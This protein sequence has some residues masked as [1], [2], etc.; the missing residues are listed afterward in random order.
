MRTRKCFSEKTFHSFIFIV[1]CFY[2]T[3]IPPPLHSPK[4][5][6]L[7]R[8]QITVL[9]A[10]SVCVGAKGMNENLPHTRSTGCQP[11]ARPLASLNEHSIARKLLWNFLLSTKRL[12]VHIVNFTTS[13]TMM[14]MMTMMSWMRFNEKSLHSKLNLDLAPLGFCCRRSPTCLLFLLTKN[15]RSD[16][17][18]ILSIGNERRRHENKLISCKVD[19]DEA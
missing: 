10:V 7:C 16:P 17:K 6:L 15:L 12:F 19:D 18:S 14:M 11:R 13:T 4:R 8:K 9:A 3:R 5:R 1:V 2:W